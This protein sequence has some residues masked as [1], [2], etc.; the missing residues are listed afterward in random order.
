MSKS[1]IKVIL[2]DTRQ[3]KTH[4]KLKEDYFA[5]QGIKV[6]SC[7]LY[8]GDYTIPSNQSVCVD[9][10]KDISELYGNVI[11]DHRRFR[12]ECIRA[13]EAGIRLIVLVENKDGVRSLN[14]ITKWK[15]PQFFRYF[16]AKKKAER[17]GLV[18]K[19]KPPTNNVTLK[20]ILWTLQNKYGVEFQ[21]CDPNDAGRIILE[22]LGNEAG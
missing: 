17:Q 2:S 13:K 8:V 22:I 15:N 14:D 20:K 4:H 12:D 1:K 3:K 9:T 7:R 18:F 5:N 10:K 6:E 19:Q 16:K 11:Q 21:F